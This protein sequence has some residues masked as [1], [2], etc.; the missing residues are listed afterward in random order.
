MALSRGIRNNNPGNLIITPIAWQGK[1][2]I[3]Q[4]TDKKFEQF[5]SMELGIRAMF[6]DLINDINKGK[7]TVRKLINEYA[8]PSENNTAQYIKD[9]CQSIGVQPD[10]Q[11]T[12][13]NESF[14]LKLGKAVIKKENGTD[15]KHVTDTQ[16]KR[17]LSLLGNVST[18]NLKVDLKTKVLK[19]AIP[20]ILVFYSVFT[21][22][23]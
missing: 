8:P 21:I 16:I 7:N 10:Q 2:P 19:Y 9:V 1:I 23:L 11:I 15:S 20:I 3:P 22:T 13:I 14:L 5:S 12:S 4:N 17:A 18:E 6:K